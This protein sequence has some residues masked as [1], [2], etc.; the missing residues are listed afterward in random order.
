[1]LSI[2]FRVNILTQTAHTKI[3]RVAGVRV[4]ATRT[5]SGRRS[6]R[7]VGPLLRFNIVTRA[8]L[9]NSEHLMFPPRHATY[10][11]THNFS[12]GTYC[13]LS[14]QQSPIW[15]PRIGSVI[16][17]VSFGPRALPCSHHAGIFVGV[18]S[19]RQSSVP[20][21][22]RPRRNKASCKST[23]KHRLAYCRQLAT[24]ESWI[25]DDTLS[26]VKLKPRRSASSTK[27]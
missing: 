4:S 18:L 26:S 22:C 17:V 5:V 6:R 11:L 9:V 14:L 3:L 19:S 12:K 21:H 2:L 8:P 7:A 16:F 20:A 13:S 15:I 24:F 27:D 25:S 23:D 10:S 1:M